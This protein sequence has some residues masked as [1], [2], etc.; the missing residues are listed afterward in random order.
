[1]NNSTL[2]H[3]DG[4]HPLLDKE[5]HHQSGACLNGTH[6][7]TLQKPQVI[8]ILVILG[9]IN[10]AVI[11]GNLLVIASVFIST[12]LR[13]VTNFFIV[14]LAVAD[15][16]LGLVV[17]P[18][19]ISLEVL[20]IWIFGDIWCQ[21]WLAVDVWMCTSSILNLCAISVDRYLAI[22]R[23]VHYRSLMSSRR[24]KLL[25][26]AVWVLAFIIC[27]PPLVGW[28]DQDEP[29]PGQFDPDANLS[30][31]GG[32]LNG[33]NASLAGFY[34]VGNGM[35]GSSTLFI[36]FDI[37]LTNET[38]DEPGAG[39]MGVLSRFFAAYDAQDE[40]G[41]LAVA[42]VKEPDNVV[43]IY[44]T[45][46]TLLEEKNLDNSSMENE[47]VRCECTLINNKG[48]VIYSALGS[49]YIPMFFMLFFYWRIYLAALR[50]SRALERGFLT[51]KGSS[52]SGSGQDQTNSGVTLRMHR[53]KSSETNSLDAHRHSGDIIIPRK[54]V[55]GSLAPGGG[56]GLQR[57]GAKKYIH[58]TAYGGSKSSSSNG[59]NSSL[60]RLT[61]SSGGGGGGEGGGD[62]ADSRAAAVRLSKRNIRWHARRFHSEAKATKTV[63]LIVGGF[64][65]CWLPFFTVYLTRAFC[66]DCCS[67][68]LFS[69]FFWLGYCN[70]ALNPLIYGLF[71]KDFRQA[72]KR[73][74]CRCFVKDEGIS[75]L[76]KQIHLPTFFE[77]NNLEEPPLT[78]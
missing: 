10:F 1:M 41:V 47:G 43:P 73:I 54:Q 2:V 46:Q 42:T 9:V 51:T 13:T 21:I 35:D 61:S 31:A 50:T 52:A 40:P 76:I 39:D 45:G 53:G 57:A 36:N 37:A 78:E 66:E 11:G 6:Y 32:D 34:P 25:I 69:I 48:Y 74:L 58:F 28:N 18:Y 49:F 72:F 67:E 8:V 4:L 5:Y 12:K 29:P 15:L 70:S 56:G 62:R 30:W 77:E 33:S 7:E 64:V 26:A 23:P 22:T 14:S 38:V 59:T 3:L 71:S 65:C 55:R 17:L 24:A 75:S 19:S 44:L 68:L 60:L 20:K 63:G 27:F 16:C